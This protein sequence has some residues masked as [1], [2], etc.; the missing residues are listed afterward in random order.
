MSDH[1]SLNSSVEG[2]SWNDGY[3]DLL[4]L[5]NSSKGLGVEKP[6]GQFLSLIVTSH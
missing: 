3:M 5:K 4:D 1:I 6:S 2:V